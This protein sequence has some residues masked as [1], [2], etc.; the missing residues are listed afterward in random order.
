MD[1]QHL[2]RVHRVGPKATTKTPWQTRCMVCIGHGF[3]FDTEIAELAG[4]LPLV[5]KASWWFASV[6]E[7]LEW[8]RTHLATHRE[9]TA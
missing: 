6:G 1:H 2:A 5:R 7:A 8:A 4:S 9:A 3:E